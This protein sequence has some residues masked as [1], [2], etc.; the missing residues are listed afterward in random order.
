MH[1]GPGMAMPWGPMPGHT[2]L[3]TAA[4]FLGMWVV[5]MAAMMLPS[6]VPLLGRQW[7]AAGRAGV[8]N[9]GRCLAIVAGG[10]LVVWAAFG[11]AVFPV[12]AALS[13]SP[14]WVRAAPI[15]GG[16]FV[17][18]AGAF[19][20]SAWKAHHLAC[21]RDAPKSHCAPPA[22][23]AAALRYGLHLGLHCCASCLNLTIILLVVG[24]MDLRAMTAV[25]AAITLER[26]APAGA[27]IG[28]AIGAVILLGALL[29]IARA[30]GL[31]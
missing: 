15:A 1:G 10:Y 19:Q 28:R 5:M 11:L 25:T 9:P 3:G 16:I 17:L 7:R 22:D 31:A 8:R 21:F 2:W 23:A 20:F 13:A 4:S 29:L 18:A 27:Q 6:F 14:A 12:G 26:L 24:M 30:S